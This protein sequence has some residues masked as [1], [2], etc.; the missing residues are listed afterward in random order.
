MEQPEKEKT[1]QKTWQ[2][3]WHWALPCAAASLLLLSS[4]ETTSSAQ[5]GARIPA[6]KVRGNSDSGS[7]AGMVR[8]NKDGKIVAIPVMMQGVVQAV[9][10]S[11]RSR[12][13]IKIVEPKPNSRSS[14]PIILASAGAASN[15]PSPSALP[16]SSLR[17]AMVAPGG[18]MM[19]RTTAYCHKEADHL[20]YG[21]MN[22]AGGR[23][24]YGG[25]VRS[26]A[27]DWSR[28]P[29]GTRFRIT[30]LPYEYVVDDYGSALVGTGTIDLYQP[31]FTAM[32]AWGVRNVP[33]QV[34]QWGSF[35]VSHRILEERK[36]VPHADHVR[37]ML[38]EI[39]K[40]AVHSASVE[41]IGNGGA[42]KTGG[43]A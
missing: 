22:A 14:S 21:R 30:G 7:L 1:W 40:K 3:T 11:Q 20:E 28:Y 39:E 8:K 35:D 33:I 36:N 10:D 32:N 15:T 27:A 18:M 37:T 13:S 2:K 19:V 29:V 5:V 41:N 25:L 6:G 43:E 34:I 4:C 31:T 16:Q 24:K 9:G 26:A 23:L 38:K 12:G 42:R 17:S